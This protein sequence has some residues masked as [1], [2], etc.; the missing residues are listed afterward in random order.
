LSSSKIG[1]AFDLPCGNF[2]FSAFSAWP[3]QDF[4][5][6]DSPCTEGTSRLTRRPLAA[7]SAT[8]PRIEAKR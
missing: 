4:D 8:H 5:Y 2:T 1:V 7:R 6:P 3:D